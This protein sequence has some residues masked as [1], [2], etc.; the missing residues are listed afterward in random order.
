MINNLKHS[1]NYL[2]GNVG[3][4]ALGFISIPFFTHYLSVEEFGIMSLYLTVLSFLVTLLS[5]GIL[6]SFKRYYFELNNDFGAFLYSNIIM[7]FIIDMILIV[8]YFYFIT[9][10]SIFLK[11][12]INILS[13]S[14]F[15]ALF[16]LF[17]K[18]HLDILQ[19]NQESG[20]NVIIEAYRAFFSLFFSIIF[21]V[22][23]SEESFLG[24]IYADL[25]VSIILASYSLFYLFKIMKYHFKLSYLKYSL[26]FGLP[27]LPSMFSSFGLSFADRLMIN[28]F[29]NTQDVGLYSFASMVAVLV[30]VVISAMSKSWQP[31]FYKA[32]NNKNNSI[33]NKTFLINTKIVLIASLFVI[34]FSYEFIVILANKDYLPATNIIMYLIIGFNFFYLYTIYGQYTSYV[35]KT[36]YDSIFTIITVLINIGLNYIY[37]PIY[38]YVVSAI[39]TVI[40]YAIMFLLFYL[41]AKYVLKFEVIKLSLVQNIHILY[42]ICIVFYLSI[43]NYELDYIYELMSKCF[44]L[45]LFII[46]SFFTNLKQ[47]IKSRY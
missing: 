12:P 43:M 21:I 13:Y 47:L 4:K 17:I 5:I 41:N 19:I 46:T 2:I 11:I 3:I 1:R 18:I 40:S 32:L 9:D 39:T 44:I 16:Y 35:K 27:A 33:L 14:I 34:F 23:L 37:I 8:I 6:G 10:L 26:L 15:I 45:I 28:S 20:K 22:L 36:Y 25:L 42:I 31:L 24:K 30:Q 29:T 7:L 38:G